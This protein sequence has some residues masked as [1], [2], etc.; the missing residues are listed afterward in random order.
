MTIMSNPGAADRGG[1]GG[2]GGAAGYA[3]E[4]AGKSMADADKA[5]SNDA[6]DAFASFTKAPAQPAFVQ[7]WSTWVMGYGGSQTTD[8]SAVAGTNTTSS[9]IYGVAVGAD[10][11]VS[12]DTVAGFALAGG[13]TNYSVVNGGTGSS[14]M[15]QLGAF[16]RHD[17]GATYLTASAAYGWQDVTTD[18]YVTVAGVDYLPA[19]TSTPTHTRAASN[20]AIASCSRGSAGLVLALCSGAGDGIRTA[21][22]RG[23]CDHRCEHVCAEPT[24]RIHRFHRAQTWSAHR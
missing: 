19:R 8:G 20:W 18:R 15:F 5:K 10:Y 11:R 1:A 12:W 7:R 3:D 6:R 21:G 24:V 14:D 22:V 16:V 13:G 2:A 23:A 9:S 4:A 17:I